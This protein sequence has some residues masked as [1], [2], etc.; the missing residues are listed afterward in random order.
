VWKLV[1]ADPPRCKQSPAATS[2]DAV[3]RSVT[4]I[5]L[6]LIIGPTFAGGRGPATRE[7]DV[8]ATLKPGHPRLIVLDADLARLKQQ[9][10]DD[11]TAKGYFAQ[12]QS[13]GDKSLSDPL[14]ERKLIGP[15]LPA[16]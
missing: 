16:R 4:L 11:A 9:I 13:A 5:V 1:F 6:C 8:L 7:G 3:Q 10:K 14:S 2:C 15:R 12:L